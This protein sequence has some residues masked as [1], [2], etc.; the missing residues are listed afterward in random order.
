MLY[1]HAQNLRLSLYI[2]LDLLSQRWLKKLE[3]QVLF[4]LVRG[5]VIQREDH[6]VHELGGFVLGHLED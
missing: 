1:L 3:Q 5:I 4:P 2:L 6:S